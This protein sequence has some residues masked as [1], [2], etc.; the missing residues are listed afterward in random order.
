MRYDEEYRNYRR[1]L[2]KLSQRKRRALAKENGMCSICCKNKADKG[3]MTC[4]EC[5]LAITDIQKRREKKDG[6]EKG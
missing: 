6:Q 1:E 3:H 5:R 2:C 4:R